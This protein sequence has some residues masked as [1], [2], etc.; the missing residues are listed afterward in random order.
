[1]TQQSQR[2]QGVMARSWIGEPLDQVEGIGFR[3]ADVNH[4]EVLVDEAWQEVIGAMALYNVDEDRSMAEIEIISVEGHHFKPE[5]VGQVMPR[6]LERQNVRKVL[7]RVSHDTNLPEEF[8][9]AKAGFTGEPDG[10]LEF[11]RAA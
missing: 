1:M 6:F 8:D 5:V 4:A 2:L 3:M 7:F 10:V 9:F 11:Q